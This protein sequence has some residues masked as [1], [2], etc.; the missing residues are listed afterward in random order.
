M[1]KKCK[2]ALLKT[3]KQ[4][5]F[6]IILSN[7]KKLKRH[8]AY[9]F[10]EKGNIY[11]YVSITHSSEI[12][13]K[14]LIKLIKNP[15]PMDKRNAYYVVEIR[16]DTKDKFG[17]KLLNWK[18]DPEDDRKIRELYKKRWFRHEHEAP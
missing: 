15:N 2:H 16:K 13:G 7:N 10:Y 9:V 11:F 5:R 8:P 12:K 18:L 3:R 1:K 17:K 6:K 14:E 4:F